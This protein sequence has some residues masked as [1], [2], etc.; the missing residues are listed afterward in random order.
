MEMSAITMDREAAQAAYERYRQA[1]K[2]TSAREDEILRAAHLAL[3]RGSAVLNI[4]E[5]LR[6]GE[7]GDHR[8]PQL[9]VCKATST[10]CFLR[11][12]HD[13]ECHFSDRPDHGANYQA[14][15]ISVDRLMTRAQAA[16]A[17]DLKWWGLKHAYELP[18]GYQFATPRP[19]IPPEV[20]PNP[21]K[22]HLY[23]VLWEAED[24]EIRTRQ[25]AAPYD[26][27][28]LKRLGP[29]GSPLFEVVSTWELTA[30][31]RMA[32]GIREH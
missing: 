4:E 31:E 32:M 13:G 19:V 5:T 28:L 12:D 22:P 6:D 16:E 10:R 30:I 18:W 9:A 23:W 8:L 20:R 15:R 24:W 14:G 7:L 21:W 29:T 11:V 2:E 26:P 1:A 17:L 25:A 3:A 27:A